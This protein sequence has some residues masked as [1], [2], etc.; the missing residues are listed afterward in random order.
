MEQPL[1]PASLQILPINFATSARPGNY[2][3]QQRSQSKLAAKVYNSQPV[4]HD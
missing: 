3:H 4:R 2:F 1:M